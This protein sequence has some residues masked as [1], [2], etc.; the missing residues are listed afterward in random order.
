VTACSNAG[1]PEWPQAL[2]CFFDGELDAI[3]SLQI[4]AHLANCPVCASEI[5]RLKT[6]KQ[7][8]AQRNVAW[9]AP[10]HVRAQIIDALAQEAGRK[11]QVLLRTTPRHSRATGVTG[12]IGRWLFVPSFAALAASLF[13]VLGPLQTRSSLEDELVASHIRSTLVNHLTDVQTSDQHTVKPWFNGKI[14]F[15]PPVT[16][17]AAQGFPLLGGR[18]DYVGGRVVA[19]LVY[20]RHGHVINLFIWPASSPLGHMTARDGYTLES[21]SSNGLNFV[22]VSDTDAEDMHRF[23]LAFLTQAE[24]Q[25]STE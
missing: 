21:W 24:S 16:D 9:R 23:R 7:T 8:V 4:E 1:N 15:A 11:Q 17:L 2:Q 10:E 25:R 20:R 13:L 5:D 22:A 12:L 14:D 6:L 18:V 19:A 3:H